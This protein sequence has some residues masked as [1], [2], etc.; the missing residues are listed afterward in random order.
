MK[1]VLA[2][3]PFYLEPMY[4]LP[5][6]GLINLATALKGLSHRVVVMD[7]VLAI[8]QGALKRGRDIY[9]DCVEKILAEAPDLVGFSAQCTIY[10][11]VIQISKKIKGRDPHVK[12][13][14]GG[15]NASFVDHK[16]YFVRPLDSYQLSF[17]QKA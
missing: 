9:D 4:N 17:V 2:F 12:I 13:V 1:I 11:A 6:L 5:P 14:I 10:P 3:P 15:H 7:F 8:R 16:P